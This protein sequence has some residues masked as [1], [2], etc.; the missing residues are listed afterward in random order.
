VS[1]KLLCSNIPP[2]KHEHDRSTP[3]KSSH[4]I[5]CMIYFNIIFRPMPSFPSLSPFYGFISKSKPSIS[6]PLSYSACFFHSIPHFITNVTFV[7]KTILE[8]PQCVAFSILLLL[9]LS[10]ILSLVTETQI[11][12]L[13]LKPSFI[14]LFVTR[15]S[16]LAHSSKFC[17]LSA[18]NRHYIPLLP[19]A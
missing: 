4:F 8:H 1:K 10:Q 17:G 15:T 6:H 13:G 5:F 12:V 7:K 19:F 9:S 2:M 14:H 11:L 16:F 3:L 18:R